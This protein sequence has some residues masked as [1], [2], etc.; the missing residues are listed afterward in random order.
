MNKNKIKLANSYYRRGD[1]S[2]TNK[3][4]LR[5]FKKYNYYQ[6]EPFRKPYKYCLY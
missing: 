6:L 2:Y 3:V 4:F 1:I 5:I